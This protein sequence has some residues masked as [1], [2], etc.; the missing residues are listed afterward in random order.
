MILVTGAT[1]PLGAAICRLLVERGEIVVG[2]GRRVQAMP[3]LAATRF[4]PVIADLLDEPA[5]T[6]A[7]RGCTAV[8]HTAALSTPWGRAAA[9]N[10]I[11]V[12][13]TARLLAGAAAAGVQRFVHVSSASVLFTGH[14]A[15][16]LT[17]DAVVPARHLCAY[18]ASKAAAERVVLAERRLAT[19]IIR[20]RAIYGPGDAV[21]LPRL[22]ARARA[23]RLR[24]LGHRQVVQS[25]TY[26]DHA[27][28]A[29][30][31]ALDAPPGRIWHVAD[32][33]PADLWDTID[34]ILGLLGLPPAGRPVPAAVV[35]TAAWAAELGHRVVPWLGE[36]ALT[37]YTAALL[38]CNQTL[39]ITAARR[40]LGY[41]PHVDRATALARTAAALAP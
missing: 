26:I 19:A 27:A 25:L 15:W 22:V 10:R 29:C 20:P 23:G 34:R 33:E 9:F 13:G 41:V 14:D 12:D 4:R 3:S 5:M 37:R 21:L 30:V 31:L 1:G 40:D 7:L 32:A 24:R 39:D 38:L 28:L 36:P 6:G 8:I 2:C 16:H 17:E 35:K 11:N 18:S